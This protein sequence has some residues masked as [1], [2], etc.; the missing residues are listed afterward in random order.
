MNT[1]KKI[2]INVVPLIDI[3][4]VLF[5]V[6]LVV[7]NFDDINNSVD[8]KKLQKKVEAL[9]AYSK[10][11]KSEN[12][13]LRDIKIDKQINMNVR[14]DGDLYIVNNKKLS[15]K[16]LKNILSYFNNYTLSVN[17]DKKDVNSYNILKDFLNN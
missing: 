17:Y 4:L 1:A 14:I 6:I 3:L 8:V 2:N 10:K 11:L 16:E 15:F 12:R 7:S 5:V 9:E 13:E